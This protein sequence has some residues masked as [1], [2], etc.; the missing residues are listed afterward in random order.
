LSLLEEEFPH[1]VEVLVGLHLLNEL[2]AKVQFGPFFD[3]G[4]HQVLGNE[5][6]TS[7]FGHLLLFC[8]GLFVDDVCIFGRIFFD[9]IECFERYLDDFGQEHLT[10]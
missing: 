1:K 5:I 10:V 7:L 6:I 2:L 3:I 8:S 4:W 9:L